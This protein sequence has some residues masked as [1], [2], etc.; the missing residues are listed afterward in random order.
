MIPR[1]WSGLR[2]AVRDLAGALLLGAGLTRPERSARDLLTVVTLHRVLPEERL[3][4]YPLRAIAVSTKEL[5]FLVAFMREH[6]TCAPLS[7]AHG[8]WAGGE[9]PPRP[10]AAIT[11]DD[12][13]LDNVEQARP[14]LEQAGLRATFF[15]PVEAV[16][17]D[18]LLWHDRLAY[19]AL[20]LLE[21]DGARAAALLGPLP[22]SDHR[23]QVTGLVA[24]SKALSDPERSSLVERVER[25]AGGDARPAWDGMM[26]WDQVRAL[27]AAGHEIGS[28][29][30]SHPLLPGLS[31]Q[32]LDA[33]LAGSRTR[34]EAEVGRPCLAFCYPN[35]DCDDRVV[36][37]VARAGYRLAV[38]TA[39]GPNRTGAHPLR[40]TRCDLQGPTTRDRAGRLSA[41][42]LALR[43][44]PTFARLL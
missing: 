2:P 6:Y 23:A 28:H 13:Q 35:G 33:E 43:L 10:L 3:A 32:R 19:A 31:D 12:G 17:S 26:G 18:R 39:W 37:A 29:S 44:H 20:R 8:R 25:A 38:L 5:A 30:L 34:L 40:L 36:A 9:R 22:G 16:D 7:E 24:R 1:T 42:R 27:A 14:V 15:L 41:A 21:L 11:F 4:A